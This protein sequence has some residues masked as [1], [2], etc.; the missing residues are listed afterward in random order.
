MDN[1]LILIFLLLLFTGGNNLGGFGG[2][3]FGNGCDNGGNNCDINGGGDRPTV[4]GAF[5]GFEPVRN[6]CYDDCDF[7]NMTTPYHHVRNE[8]C[9]LQALLLIMMLFLFREMNAPISAVPVQARERTE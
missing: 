2:G 7:R 9:D 3:I 5:D 1:S 8:V 6:G 4:R